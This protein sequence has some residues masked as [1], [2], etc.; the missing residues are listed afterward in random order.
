M[1]LEVGGIGEGVWVSKGGGGS[2]LEAADWY[3]NWLRSGEIPGAG[4]EAEREEEIFPFEM[5]YTVQKSGTPFVTVAG[6]SLV[7]NL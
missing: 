3:I 1:G 6:I 5:T 2:C 4:R 7:L